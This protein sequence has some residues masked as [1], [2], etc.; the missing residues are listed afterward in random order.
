MAMNPGNLVDSRALRT[1]TPSMMIILQRFL[2]QPF[3]SVL[4]LADP[5]MR[6]S[7]NAAADLVELATNPALDQGGF[8]SLLSK[9]ESAPDSYNEEVQE[10][11]W[12]QTMNW[13]GITEQNI[14][15][16]ALLQ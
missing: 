8:Y 11:I 3:K 1:N 2:L 4:R 12:T 13:A 16:G 15:L 5:T 9:T 14:G 7:T 10:K 6:T